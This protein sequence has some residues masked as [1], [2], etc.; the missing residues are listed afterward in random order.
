MVNRPS[1]KVMAPRRGARF[2]LLRCYA[3]DA[4][5]PCGVEG[6]EKLALLE[7]EDGEKLKCHQVLFSYL[8]S[9]RSP[10]F[11]HAR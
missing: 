3:D 11:P 10:K 1:I 7:I 4:S 2:R 5:C 6:V 8:K 9:E